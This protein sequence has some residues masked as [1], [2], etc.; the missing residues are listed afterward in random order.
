ML[1]TNAGLAFYLLLTDIK[2]KN[3]TLQRPMRQVVNFI[4][5]LCLFLYACVGFLPIIPLSIKESFY[6]SNFI[7]FLTMIATLILYAVWRP[8]KKKLGRNKIFISYRRKD[9]ADIT[10]R[11]VDRLNAKFGSNSI[12]RD[13]DSIPLG[14]NFSDYI[15]KLLES[16]SV[17]L[18]VIGKRWVSL[19]N[20]KSERDNPD[21]IDYVQIEIE[22]ALLHHLPIIPVLLQNASVPA[23]TQLPKAIEALSLQNGIAIRPDPDFNMDIQRL[24]HGIKAGI[25]KT[26]K[27]RKNYGYKKMMKARA[28]AKSGAKSKTKPGTRSKTL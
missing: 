2:K 20:S 18:V 15:D 23:K 4:L 21:S 7:I 13:V 5:S 27:M 6:N 14:V 17:C 19:C 1:M 3:K 25:K 11:I 12:L 8:D 22:T 26:K 9:S 16:S 28:L 24:I 10:G